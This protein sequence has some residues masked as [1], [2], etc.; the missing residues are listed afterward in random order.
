VISDNLEL[1]LDVIVADT[2]VIGILLDQNYYH[3]HKK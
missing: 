3:R 2:V 1:P